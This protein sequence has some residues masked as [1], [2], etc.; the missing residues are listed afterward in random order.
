MWRAW[1]CRRKS[2][3]SLFLSYSGFPTAPPLDGGRRQSRHPAVWPARLCAGVPTS[4]HA[5]ARGSVANYS[6]TMAR[7]FSSLA[8]SSYRR[9]IVECKAAACSS[10]LPSRARP[11]V[12]PR[13]AASS[14]TTSGKILREKPKTQAAWAQP[15]S[16][17][18]GTVTV[19]QQTCYFYVPLA[20]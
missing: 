6:A 5:I 8:H 2:L 16:A 4:H 12:R 15:V 3:H 1:L 11:P 19:S 9:R 14:D 18:I 13:I 17:K 10:R 20:R 7:P